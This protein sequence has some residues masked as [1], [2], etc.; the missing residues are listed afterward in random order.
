MIVVPEHSKPG[1][2]RYPNAEEIA[3]GLVEG[4]IN[5]GLLVDGPAADEMI[6]RFRDVLAGDREAV[7]RLLAAC[8]L[9]V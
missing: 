8:G 3:V 2:V 7:R 9:E 6:R 4:M 1:C 5:D